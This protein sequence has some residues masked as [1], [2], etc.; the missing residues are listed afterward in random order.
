MEATSKDGPVLFGRW[1]IWALS[2]TMLSPAINAAVRSRFWRAVLLWG[3]MITIE[4]ARI[5]IRMIRILVFA[6]VGCVTAK[7]GAPGKCNRNRN[8]NGFVAGERHT[9]H[10]SQSARRMGHP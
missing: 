5:G 1:S 4:K 6:L 8:G 2:G 10:P 7:D 3:R 9:S